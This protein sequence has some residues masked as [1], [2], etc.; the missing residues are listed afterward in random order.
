MCAYGA[1]HCIILLC[2]CT[3]FDD[4]ETPFHIC[5]ATVETDRNIRVYFN[6]MSMGNFSWYI[7]DFTVAI[8]MKWAWK[9]HDIIYDYTKLAPG[10]FI[11]W[12]N[13]RHL[14]KRQCL[15]NGT[16]IINTILV[17]KWSNPSR[18]RQ[19]Y[20]NNNSGSN[21]IY[22]VIDINLCYSKHFRRVAR[23][24]VEWLENKYGSIH[25]WSRERMFCWHSIEL[26]YVTHAFRHFHRAGTPSYVLL[27]EM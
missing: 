20:N 13:L 17:V 22:F 23:L 18:I 10:Y 2:A 15:W 16:R 26:L 7:S 6:K 8:S 24:I 4:T 19:V 11:T 9:L 25:Y 1:F 5:C 21:C 3:R 14:Q 12:C 27:G